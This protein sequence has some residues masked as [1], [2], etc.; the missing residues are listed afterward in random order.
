MHNSEAETRMWE[1]GFGGKMQGGDQKSN[2]LG[3]QTLPPTPERTEWQRPTVE[4]PTKT[5]GEN[6]VQVESLRSESPESVV[7]LRSHHAHVDGVHTFGNKYMPFAA[8]FEHMAAEA[9]VYRSTRLHTIN[10]TAA[11]SDDV[12]YYFTLDNQKSTPATKGA[13]PKSGS[14]EHVR[15]T[16]MASK[17]GWWSSLMQPIK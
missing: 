8:G 3:Q 2:T 7:Q 11:V 1:S 17:G 5:A 16:R 10:P 12:S 14:S 15:N 6:R 9:P 13:D 4:T